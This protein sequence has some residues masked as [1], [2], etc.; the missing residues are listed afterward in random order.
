MAWT[1]TLDTAVPSGSADPKTLDTI[2]QNHKKAWQERLNTDLYLPLT[3]TEISDTDAGEHRKVTLRVQTSDPTNEADK[4]WLYTKDVSS[5]AELHWEDEDGNVKQIMSGGNILGTV[6]DFVPNN[7]QYIVATD[8][9]G[10]GTVD[11]IK[12]NTS[13]EVVLGAVTT[14]PDT[15][16]L[17]TDAAP[18]ADE[19]IAN[20]KYVDDSVAKYV[21]S[22]ANCAVASAYTLTH[23]LGTDEIF[24]AVQFKDTGNLLGLGINRIYNVD[25]GRSESNENGTAI[26]NITSTQVTLQTGSNGAILSYSASGGFKNAATG[27]LR[28]LCW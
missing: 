2:I 28:V 22:W 6:D 18:T 19:E 3:G 17:T 24:V 23:G 11:L 14:L 10:S 21:S 25:V 7:N 26:Q 15:S 4:G 13:D 27:Q 12:A 1:Y 5:K 16:K 9:A 8:N 20:K